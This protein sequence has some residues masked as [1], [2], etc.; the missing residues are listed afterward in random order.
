MSET[1][2]LSAFFDELVRDAVP[3]VSEFLPRPQTS[4]GGGQYVSEGHWHSEVPDSAAGTQNGVETNEGN[5][6]K[7]LGIS[8][9]D[10]WQSS[11]SVSAVDSR[12][13]ASGYNDAA[14]S[15]GA[16]D[17]IDF[18]R[19][20]ARDP[21]RSSFDANGMH[22]PDQIT[23]SSNAGKPKD[24]E[25]TTPSSRFVPYG[26]P[27]ISSDAKDVTAN[28]DPQADF[29]PFLDS[30]GSADFDALKDSGIVTPQ[31]IQ[32]KLE[33]NQQMLFAVHENLKAGKCADTTAFFEKMQQN[34]MFLAL[35][36]DQ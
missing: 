23:H 17:N 36:V 22:H 32:Q 8:S 29:N 12:S 1:D 19:Y 2:E 28:S 10:G 13:K 33:E 27:D 24:S 35:I 31:F 26:V 7:N 21:R 14:L 3:G 30:L 18:E 6:V 5:Y 20:D 15:K 16:M 9:D 4:A 25:A 11:T 34:L